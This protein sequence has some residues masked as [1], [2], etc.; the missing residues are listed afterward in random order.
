MKS[1]N[2]NLYNAVRIEQALYLAWNDVTNVLDKYNV[3]YN[4][5][6]KKDVVRSYAKIIIFYCIYEHDNSVEFSKAPHRDIVSLHFTS[7]YPNEKIENASPEQIKSSSDAV[8]RDVKPLV[9]SKLILREKEGREVFYSP[10]EI[11]IEHYETNV[12]NSV[13]EL[14]NQVR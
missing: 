9:D 5:S 12:L 2:R 13:R 6:I 8:S 7:K 14:I 1:K 4:G 10:S 11:L 3:E